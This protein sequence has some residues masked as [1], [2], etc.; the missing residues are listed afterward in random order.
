MSSTPHVDDLLPEYAA[1]TRSGSAATEI[2]AH[3]AT[4]GRC[5]HVLGEIDDVLAGLALALTAP[6]PPPALRARVLESAHRAGRFEPFAARVASIIDCGV[7]VAR[8]L[9]QRID[10]PASWIDGPVGT[11]LIH[12]PAGPRVAHA[13]CGFIRLPAGTVFPMHRHLGEEQTL[14]LQGAYVDSSGRTLRPGDVDVR[15]RD[16]EHSYTVLPGV[17]LV[18]L[19]VLETGIEIPGMPGIHL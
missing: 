3:I 8:A 11:R 7:D 12:L 14:V 17:D 18:Y 2:E 4:C 13:N 16:S 15:A 5:A 1:G 6:P 9:L 10:D 19:V